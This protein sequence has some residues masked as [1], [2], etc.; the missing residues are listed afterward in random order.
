MSAIC[1]VKVGARRTKKNTNTTN[2]PTPTPT[3][4]KRTGVSII[5]L[6]VRAS[7]GKPCG[8]PCGR[9]SK[10][11]RSEPKV[12]TENK[13][14]T[15][16]PVKAALPSACCGPQK[17]PYN[18][19]IVPNP[20]RSRAR[21]MHIIMQTCGPHVNVK[22]IWMDATFRC[23]ARLVIIV[24]HSLRRANAPR[25]NGRNHYGIM[26]ICSVVGARAWCLLLQRLFGL[27]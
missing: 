11:M 23:N 12:R 19:G 10:L 13:N 7:C 3:D 27:H 6:A 15:T 9:G 21:E 24:H 20:G 17:Y 25:A 8:K 4:T 16:C 26:E 22:Y 5:P 14:G 1:L 2:T 18:G